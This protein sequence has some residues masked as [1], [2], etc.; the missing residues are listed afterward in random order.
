MVLEQSGGVQAWW[1]KI[2]SLYFFSFL[3][4]LKGQENV[5]EIVCVWKPEFHVL[6]T[7]KL[8]SFP[9]Q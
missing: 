1:G 8:I 6:F 3:Y 7:K 9:D 5:Y 4:I 2:L